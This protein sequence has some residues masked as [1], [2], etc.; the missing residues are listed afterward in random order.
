MKTGKRI[1]IIGA[2]PCGLGAG[3]RLSELGYDNWIILERE[4]HVGGLAASFTDETGFTY[5]IGG[6]VMF[7]HYPYFDRVVTEAL[8]DDYLEHQ[9]ESWIWLSDR[10]IPY[11]FQNNIRYLPKRKMIECLLGLAECWQ[12]R[13]ESGNFREWIINT[14]GSGIARYFMLPYNRKNWGFPLTKMD[15]RWIAERVSVVDFKRVLNNVLFKQDDISFGPNATFK[16]PLYGGTGGLFVRIADFFRDRIRLSEEVVGL[17][18]EGKKVYLKD[19]RS[20]PYDFLISTMPL[21]Q[22][23]EKAEPVPKGVKEAAKNLSFNGGLIVGVAFKRPTDSTKCWIY[24]PE[25]TSPFYRVTY[26]SNYS[27]KIVPDIK[28]YFLLLAETT[29]SRYRKIPKEKIVDLTLEGFLN[30]RLIKKEDLKRIAASFTI[31]IDHSYPI[32]TMKRNKALSILHPFF[33]GYNVLSRG[34]FGGYIYEIGNTDH[35]FMQGKEAVDR[36]VLGKEE[37][38]WHLPEP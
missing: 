10:F 18:L 36:V 33:E 23:A 32:P 29:Y 17:N 12:E 30:T 27:P 11:P 26:L 14:F 31:D 38:V 4:N 13:R 8:R 15:H 5:D 20:E 37:K 25:K 22:L 7:S 24:F 21:D 2:G 28:R 34:R 1:I 16:F 35:S 3:W 19:G 6:H 9:R